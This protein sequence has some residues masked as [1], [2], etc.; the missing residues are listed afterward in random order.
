MLFYTCC[1]VALH[2]TKRKYVARPAGVQK[3]KGTFFALHVARRKYVARPALTHALCD[4]IIY[5][6]H[7][8]KRALEL[9]ALATSANNFEVRVCVCV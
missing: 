7:N 6:D 5:V 3:L 2:V 8:M 1:C 9:C 4:Y